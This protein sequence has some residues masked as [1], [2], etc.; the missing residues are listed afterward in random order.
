MATLPLGGQKSGG[1]RF[2]L[3]VKEAKQSSELKKSQGRVEEPRPSMETQT[4][5]L[6]SDEEDDLLSEDEEEL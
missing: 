1:T 5:G 4:A 6:H 2:S 3:M